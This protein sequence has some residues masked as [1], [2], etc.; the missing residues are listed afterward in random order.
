MRFIK[1]TLIIL[2]TVLFISFVGYFVYQA[3]CF[4]GHGER[5]LEDYSYKVYESIDKKESINFGSLS[6]IG[7]YCDGSLH[8]SEDYD[9]SDNILI[10]NIGDKTYDFY[11]IDSDLIFSKAF[12]KYLYLYVGENT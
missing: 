10:I 12:N 8:V 9:Y 1:K 5:S 2:S 11:L 6:R 3:S 4:Y 7:L